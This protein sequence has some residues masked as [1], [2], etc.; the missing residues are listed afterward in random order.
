MYRK[1]V[2]C[3]K[4]VRKKC[5]ECDGSRELARKNQ[6]LRIASP[7]KRGKVGKAQSMY[8]N[9]L[10]RACDNQWNIN[11]SWKYLLEV[12]PDKCPVFNTPLDFEHAGGIQGRNP[13]SPSLDRFD[14]SKGYTKDNVR[15]VSWRAN[16]LKSNGTAEEF[17]Q[18][19]KYL[20][21]DS[22]E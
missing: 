17:K 2:S 16:S 5:R 7:R 9:A 14:N 6:K 22:L 21:G 11:I 10:K 3:T 1:A 20:E 4:G 19:I 13:N 18:I 8:W 15:I 12:M